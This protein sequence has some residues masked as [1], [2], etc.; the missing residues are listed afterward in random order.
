MVTNEKKKKDKNSQTRTGRRNNIGGGKF[1]EVQLF[2]KVEAGSLSLDESKT[3][4]LI[5]VNAEENEILIGKF[6]EQEVSEAIF[7]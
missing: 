2:G 3:E 5:Q 6:S 7:R 4:D 1:K